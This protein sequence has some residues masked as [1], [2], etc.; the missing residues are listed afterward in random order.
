MYCL[1]LSKYPTKLPEMIKLSLML[2]D[3][4]FLK[5]ESFVVSFASVESAPVNNI[6]LNQSEVCYFQLCGNKYENLNVIV[7][8]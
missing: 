3:H 8:K 5:L 2:S 4:S 7:F 1:G 6:Q